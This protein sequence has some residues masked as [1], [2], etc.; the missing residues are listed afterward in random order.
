MN[1]RLFPRSNMLVPKQSIN[2][3][4]SRTF[5]G[6]P[7][8]FFSLMQNV[9]VC[10]S[11]ICYMLFQEIHMD[12]CFEMTDEA[13]EA[14]VQFC[15]NLSILLFHGCPKITGKICDFVILSIFDTI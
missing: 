1:K 6:E 13:V 4:V 8:F 12:G 14:A 2:N 11:T 5:P 7:L 10:T 3:Q 9:H 15:P